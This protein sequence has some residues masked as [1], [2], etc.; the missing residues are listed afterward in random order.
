MH[1]RARYATILV[2][3]ILTAW[4]HAQTVTMTMTIAGSPIGKN[5]YTSQPDGT[6]ESVTDYEVA[7]QKLHSRLTGKRVKGAIVEATLDESN[8]KVTGKVVI[9]AGKASSW[10]NGAKMLDEDPVPAHRGD[11]FAV[12]HPQTSVAIMASLR[13][14]P[15]AGEAR[16]FDLNQFKELVLKASSRTTQVQRDG[17][18][19]PITIVSVAIQGLSIEYAFDHEGRPLGM[20][21]PQQSAQ[22]TAFDGVFADPIAQFPELSQSTYKFKNE[23]KLSVPMRDGIKLVADVSRPADNDKHPVILIRT[24]YGRAASLL[25]AGFWSRR[26]Y[27]VVS[28]DVRGKGDSDGDFEPLDNEVADGKDTLDWIVKQPW[29][30]GNIGMIGGSYLGYVQWAA[31]VTKHPALKCIIPQVSPPD[32]LHN[33]PVENGAIML[34]GNVWWYRVVGPKASDVTSI[35]DKIHGSGFLATP[36]T[37]VDDQ[38]LGKNIPGFDRFIQ[39]V[40]ARD[41]TRTFSQSQIA[42]VRIPVLHVSG[43]WDG[44]GIGT[45]LNWQALRPANPNQ[46]LVFGPWD[47]FFNTKSKFADNEYGSGAV[48]DLDTI[49]LRFFDT[50]LKHKNAKINVVPRAKVF[51]TG[52]NKWHE[53]TDWPPAGSKSTTYYLAGGQAAGPKS[54]GALSLTGGSGSDQYDY[55]PNHPH[56]TGTDF[57]ITDQQTT[58]FPLAKF[59]KDTLLYFSPKLAQDTTFTGPIEAKLFVS[60]SGRDAT[61]AM[62][63]Y[64]QDERGQLQMV[65]IGGVA[66]TTFSNGSY[67]ALKPNQVVPI[68]IEHWL[69]AHR[70][71]KGHRLVAT[72]QSDMFPRF[73]RNPGT[74]EL[75]TTATKMIKVRQ[76][77]YKSKR[78]PSSIRIQRLP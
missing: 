56:Y 76:T 14:R 39:K 29:C 7:G 77:I 23:T 30:D 10:Q 46:Y 47:H 12:L 11:Y 62:Q 59:P 55:D 52:E 78:Y 51:V 69:F 48:L 26:G 1:L 13:A 19:E 54:K 58:R 64:D 44:D 4:A 66:R 34:A 63:I 65:G 36:I 17:K 15:E 70:F 43:C 32:P 9:A 37:R 75:E 33:L 24:P 57:G 6:F 20:N 3:G 41:W 18:P 38:V 31:A 68:T 50:F 74:G 25:N 28:Q 40:A 61:F 45:W 53:A 2:A 16:V 49:Y 5:V 42:G 22:F 72:I 60:T 35:F 27:V 8:G 21:I 73:A 71:A 67:R